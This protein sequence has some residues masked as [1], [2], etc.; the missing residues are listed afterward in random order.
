[1]MP[2]KQRP[3]MIYKTSYKYN[4]SKYKLGKEEVNKL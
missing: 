2:F 3:K 4:S 1:M